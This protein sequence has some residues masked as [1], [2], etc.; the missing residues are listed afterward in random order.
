MSTVL[1]RWR[2]SLLSVAV[3]VARGLPALHAVDR[4]LRA[5][6]QSLRLHQTNAPDNSASFATHHHAAADA[7][8]LDLGL[9]LDGEGDDDFACFDYDFDSVPAMNH[10]N[11]HPR[12]SS[13]SPH[14]GHQPVMGRAS[15]STM[16]R[17]TSGWWDVA[18]AVGETGL[19]FSLVV[20]SGI[21][22]VLR[23]GGQSG[24]AGAPAPRGAHEGLARAALTAR[25]SAQMARRTWLQSMKGPKGV[26]VRKREWE[27]DPGQGKGKG[28]GKDRR[29]VPP[30]WAVVDAA[31]GAMR[32]VG[33]GVRGVVEAATI[34]VAGLHRELKA[35]REAAGRG[36]GGGEGL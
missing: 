12:L 13:R 4:L 36:R 5:V 7:A 18:S 19:A 27:R 24:R 20:L 8:G 17:L 28:K 29:A 15:S 10:H 30:G 26:G 22:T 11:D 34:G 31:G 9:G 32:A 14:L 16:D 23:R 21:E 1:P 3:R 33:L 35:P 2:P 25:S 6:S